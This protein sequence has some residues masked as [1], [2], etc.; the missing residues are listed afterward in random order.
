MSKKESVFGK[1][2]ALVNPMTASILIWYATNGFLVLAIL[3]DPSLARLA[4]I[5][6]TRV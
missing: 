6:I 5:R 3:D 4:P 2:G 1:I